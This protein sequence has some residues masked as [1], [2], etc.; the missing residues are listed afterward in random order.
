MSTWTFKTSISRVG[1]YTV[2]ALAGAV[3]AGCTVGYR[4][5]EV[6]PGSL[7]PQ[8][9][10][11]RN[12]VLDAA[13]TPVA[14]VPPRGFC[15]DPETAVTGTAGAFVL[16]G[17]C[18]TIDPIPVL[19]FVPQPRPSAV[20]D[21]TAPIHAIL[22]ASV[23][24]EPMLV[25]VPKGEKV[26]ELEGALQS[27]IGKALLGRG[28]DPEKTRL[29]QTRRRGDTLYVLIE[30]NSDPLVEG[31]APRFWRAFTEVNDRMTVLTI[32]A[33]DGVY[34]GDAVLLRHLVAFREELRG[35]NA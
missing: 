1:K 26:A 13:G 5:G 35:A 25:D 14:I 10:D 3:I 34:A 30:D 16:L 24:T 6:D 27:G 22:S 23:G 31:A 19:G 11:P 18:G 9:V 33:F 21:R 29:L 8:P 17:D 28:G 7:Q 4:V 20:S 32:S 15:I 12:A 2:L